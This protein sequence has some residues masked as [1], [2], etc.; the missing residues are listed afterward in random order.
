MQRVAKTYKTQG[1]AGF[2]RGGTALVFRQGT[3]WASRQGFTDLIRGMFLQ[4]HGVGGSKKLSVLEEAT[5]G[6]LGTLST[7]LFYYYTLR[8]VYIYMEPTL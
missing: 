3:N 5:S 1:F 6:I 4:S 8:W 2:Y 7:W